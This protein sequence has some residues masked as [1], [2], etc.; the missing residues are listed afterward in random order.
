MKRLILVRHAKTESY[1]FEKSDFERRLLPRG[2]EDA[3]LI[4]NHLINEELIPEV[5]ISSPAKRALQ[6]ATIF[7]KEMNISTSNILEAPFL[8]DGY[9][10]GEL[11]T[12]LEKFD[13]EETIILFGHNPDITYSSIQ[14]GQENF[15]HYPTSV[16][17]SIIFPIDSWKALSA[18]NGKTELYIYP[19]KLK[20]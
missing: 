15:Y 11:M 3:A 19:K 20:S 17:I 18:G 12:Y 1:S 13:Q 14:L 10:T 7:A 5:F 2:K 4:A 16:A 8:Y 9:T 6:T